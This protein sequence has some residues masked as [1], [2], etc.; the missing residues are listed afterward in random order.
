MFSMSVYIHYTQL[1]V[2]DVSLSHFVWSEQ[3]QQQQQ[4][5]NGPY[6]FDSLTRPYFLVHLPSMKDGPH[7]QQGTV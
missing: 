1:D 6:S 4:S 7:K 2:D 5:L 3:Q